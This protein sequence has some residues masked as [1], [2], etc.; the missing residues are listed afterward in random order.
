MPVK[1]YD[2]EDWF[3]RGRKRLRRGTDYDCGQASMV[4]QIRNAANR[5]GYSVEI[6]EL[7]DG[8]VI[9]SSKVEGRSVGCPS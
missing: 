8:L 9:V 6:E 1:I 2:W 5:Y 7:E 3:G 4:Q